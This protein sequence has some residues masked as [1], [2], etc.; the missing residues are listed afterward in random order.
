MLF[1]IIISSISKNNKR[2]VNAKGKIK[3]AISAVPKTQ[4]F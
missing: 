3:I 1:V 4:L 2:G